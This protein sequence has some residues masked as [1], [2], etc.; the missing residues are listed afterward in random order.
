M[1]QRPGCITAFCVASIPLIPLE[2]PGAYRMIPYAD[3]WVW[4]C[5][6]IGVALHVAGIILLFQLR[7]L[8][9]Y[10]ALASWLFPTLVLI[11]AQLNPAWLLAAGIPLLVVFTTLYWSIEF[12]R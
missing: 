2:A 7:R 8:G 11:L 5:M 12:L 1:T 10:L 6:F 9:Y 4:V 3:T